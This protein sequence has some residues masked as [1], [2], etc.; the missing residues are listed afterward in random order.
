MLTT[1]SLAPLLLV[2]R[3]SALA[4]WTSAGGGSRLLYL[5]FS[6]GAQGDGVLV[7]EHHDAES[8]SVQ[9]VE[10]LKE[11]GQLLG[12]VAQRAEGRA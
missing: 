1:A 3:P 2:Q 9:L 6:L 4:G 5:P 12:S 7:I 10:L 8:W 11:M